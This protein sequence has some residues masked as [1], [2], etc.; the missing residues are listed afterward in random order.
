MF[1]A[2]KLEW[3]RRQFVVTRVQNEKKTNTNFSPSLAPP[4]KA[5]KK[6]AGYTR[7]AVKLNLLIKNTRL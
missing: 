4:A 1:Q 3:E 2:A 6:V 7:I 5:K